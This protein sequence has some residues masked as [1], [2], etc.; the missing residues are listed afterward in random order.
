MV[1]VTRV[2]PYIGL[3]PSF[4]S[5]MTIGRI[6]DYLEARLEAIKSREEEEEED[7]ER[8]KERERRPLV[9]TS[10]KTSPSVASNCKPSTIVAPISK[11]RDSV[12]PDPLVCQNH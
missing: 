8:D 10:I 4:I 5:G 6:M 7:E 11:P 2:C 3:V 12:S 1:Y 9:G